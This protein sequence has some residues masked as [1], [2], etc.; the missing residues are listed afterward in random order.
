LLKGARSFIA[1]KILLMFSTL[2][3]RYRNLLGIRKKRQVVRHG[4]RPMLGKFVV[5]GHLKMNVNLEISSEQW[6]WLTL[7]GWRTIEFPKDRRRYIN[8]PPESLALLLN[9][10]P[11]ERETRHLQLVRRFTQAA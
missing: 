2:K 5:R 10:N 1:R 9:A 8:L 7:A 4:P 3:N 11:A 6:V